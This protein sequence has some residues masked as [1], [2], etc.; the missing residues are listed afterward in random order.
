MSGDRWPLL[1]KDDM[2]DTLA[3]AGVGT[4]GIRVDGVNR[5]D[6]ERVLD[7]EQD[8]RQAARQARLDEPITIGDVTLE[9][10]KLYDVR[11]Q[12]GFLRRGPEWKRGMRY[13]G[14]DFAHTYSDDEYVVATFTRFGA[15]PDPT[16]SRAKPERISPERIIE[17]VPVKPNKQQ[18]AAIADK[19]KRDAHLLEISEAAR[20]RSATGN[21]S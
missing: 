15:R 19:G 10:G 21:L 7:A 12:A 11:E 13:N 17:V 5:E 14:T 3:H 18:L 16:W 6:M 8:R 1:S 4:I 2:I 9:V 20:A